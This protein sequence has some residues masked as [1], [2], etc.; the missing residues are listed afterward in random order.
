[1]KNKLIITPKTKIHNLLIEYPE[2]EEVLMDVSPAFEKLKNPVL[3]KTIGKI[4]TVQ[5][6]ANI[7]NISVANLINILRKKVGQEEFI[8]N[9][10]V[11]SGINYHKPDWFDENKIAKE[12]DVKPMLEAG[13][14]PVNQVISEVKSIGENEIYKMT[15]PFL[16]VPLIEKVTGL[17][18]DNWTEKQSESS[19]NIYFIRKK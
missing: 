10:A 8:E 1:M 6:A 2:L 16:P 5:Q 9:E 19:F 15:A 14:H 12:L 3:R 17:G 11:A 4:A 7:G 13:E 18:F